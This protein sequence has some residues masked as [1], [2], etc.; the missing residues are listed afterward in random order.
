VSSAVLGAAVGSAGGGFLS[1][2]L[3]RKTALKTAD[4]FFVVGAVV[5]A[6]SPDAAILIFG[7]PPPCCAVSRVLIENVRLFTSML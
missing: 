2:R 7:E 4:A 5:M 1:D 6:L 3:G